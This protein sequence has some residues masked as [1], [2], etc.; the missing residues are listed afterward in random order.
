MFHYFLEI[1]S[2]YLNSFGY[3]FYLI[4]DLKVSN[5]DISCDSSNLIII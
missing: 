3:K 4:I 1:L 2:P 5:L